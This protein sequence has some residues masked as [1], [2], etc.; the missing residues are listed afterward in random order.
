MLFITTNTCNQDTYYCA[1]CFSRRKN[2]LIL[3][4]QLTVR[5]HAVI[6]K[7]IISLLLELWS[8]STG[9]SC[10]RQDSYIHM[11]NSTMSDSH[12]SWF[13]LPLIEG[14]SWE[15]PS[16]QD[17]VSLFSSLCLWQH[18]LPLC[19]PLAV[20]YRSIFLLLKISIGLILIDLT[21]S[22]FSTW[23]FHESGV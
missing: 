2:A 8:P 1:C 4:T 10:F 17:S 22:A 3:R 14:S 20:I 6:G 23:Q 21:V 9:F 13:Y 5:V 15:N 11:Y 16:F 7:C 19:L 18:S 12:Q